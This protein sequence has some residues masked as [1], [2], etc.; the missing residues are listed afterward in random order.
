MLEKFKYSIQLRI[1]LALILVFFLVLV[2]V[3]QDELFYD[4]FIH[5]FKRLS[6]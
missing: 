5:F 6:F 3:L 4:P 1:I 2:R